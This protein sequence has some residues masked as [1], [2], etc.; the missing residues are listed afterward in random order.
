MHP[1]RSRQRR[2]DDR[3]EIA[4]NTAV[5]TAV[6]LLV[7]FCVQ[8]GIWFYGRQ[9]AASAAQHAVDAARVEQGT[10]SAGEATGHDYLDQVGGLDTATVTV[11]RTIDTVT[12]TV[13]GDPPSILGFFHVGV[14]VTV[15]GPV[16][17][18]VE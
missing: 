1:T 6:V 10:A 8:F 16:E 15:T 17:R 7:F 5:F 2:W 18:I 14:T 12:A 3:G 13:S 9:V 11:N 4:A